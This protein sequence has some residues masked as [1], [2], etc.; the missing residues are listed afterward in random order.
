MGHPIT[1]DRYSLQLSA[2]RLQAEVEA[3]LKEANPHEIDGPINWPALHVTGVLLDVLGR[4]WVVKIE[5]ASPEA[6]AL[7]RYVE[8]V[9]EERGW[10]D[11]SV[12]TEW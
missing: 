2:H 8:G 5:E 11:V 7:S 9:L 12:E 10:S 1:W 6:T 3:I 4:S